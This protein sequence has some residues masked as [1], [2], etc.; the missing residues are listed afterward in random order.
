MLCFV[1]TVDFV[2]EEQR[3]LLLGRK[4]TFRLGQ[5]IT[6]L[7]HPIGDGTELAEDAPAGSGKNISEGRLAGTGGT[8]KNNRAK[9]VGG[10]QSAEQFSF[11]EK[12]LLSN[13]FIQR[14]RTHPHG[15]RLGFPAILTFFCG[16]KLG[17]AGYKDRTVYSE[18]WL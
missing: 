8:M 12:M 3:F 4:P 18:V 11:A 1:E 16:K 6:E 2:D 14:L 9:P 5:N 10:E 7:L 17:H 15:K 13:E